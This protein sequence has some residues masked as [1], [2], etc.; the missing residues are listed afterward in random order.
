MK[1]RPPM[2]FHLRILD[3]DRDTTIGPRWRASAAPQCMGSGLMPIC[4]G[5]V[6][7]DTSQFRAPQACQ[8]SSQAHVR[9][10]RDERPDLRLGG[11]DEPGGSSGPSDGNRGGVP[12]AAGDSVPATRGEGRKPN[13]EPGW[14]ASDSMADRSFVSVCCSF[15]WSC[16]TTSTSCSFPPSDAAGAMAGEGLD[17]ARTL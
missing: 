2:A 5:Y 12:D 8:G 17:L 16:F 9:T 3:G 11:L 13:V 7:P 4:F 6:L 10:I 14:W 15:S 1:D